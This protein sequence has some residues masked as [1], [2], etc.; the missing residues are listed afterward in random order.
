VEHLK[1]D[2]YVVSTMSFPRYDTPTGKKILEYLDGK[3]GNPVKMDPL[4]AAVFYYNDRKAALPEIKALS[5]SSDF[6]ILDRYK[7]S[8]FAYQS[9]KIKDENKRLEILKRLQDLE[10]DIPEA[11]LV[12]LLKVPIEITQK[13]LEKEKK[14]DMHENDIE[15][16]KRTNEIYDYLCKENKNWI[17][18]DCM[19]DKKLMS[20]EE[21]HEKVYEAV[22]KF[23]IN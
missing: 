23:F 3:F 18:I 1:K 14:K 20:I 8:N 10:K 2:G 21:I 6:L 12:I 7:Y 15:F 22:K 16:L 17:A 5:K 9:A 13:M 11:D 19:K 4:K